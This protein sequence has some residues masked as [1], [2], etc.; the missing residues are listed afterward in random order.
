MGSAAIH[1]PIT[2]LNDTMAIETV[3]PSETEHFEDVVSTSSSANSA[4]DIQQASP[5]AEVAHVEEADGKITWRL[6]LAF[7]VSRPNSE[8]SLATLI[9]LQA[10]VF[11]LI[12]YETTYY[13]SAPIVSVVV[14]DLGP[15]PSY[16][17]IL[18]SWSLCAALVVSIAGRFGDIFGRRYFMLT[19]SALAIIGAISKS[20]CC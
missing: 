1:A 7:I 15:D 18:N 9:L 17:W 6:I 11:Q 3:K 10:L 5:S 4:R 14:A 20:T 12:C 8:L 2:T 13:V 16:T 19:G